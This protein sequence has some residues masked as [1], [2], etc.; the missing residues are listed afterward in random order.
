MVGRAWVGL[1]RQL[2]CQKVFHTLKQTTNKTNN[3]FP[4]ARLGENSGD[5]VASR[6]WDAGGYLDWS[7]D[8]HA[9][10]I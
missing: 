9:S 1:A 8:G 6:L 7:G 3:Y 2:N 4:P 10:V 5:G